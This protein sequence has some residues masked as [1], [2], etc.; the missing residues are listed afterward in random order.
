M[1]VM[2]SACPLVFVGS[3]ATNTTADRC[4]ESSRKAEGL[5]GRGLH[6]LAQERLPDCP[7][8]DSWQQ[9]GLSFQRR[10]AHQA[11]QPR[12]EDGELAYA[13]RP[14]SARHSLQMNHATPHDEHTAISPAQALL[15]C[16][17]CPNIQPKRPCFNLGHASTWARAF[18]MLRP[19]PGRAFVMLRTG[20]CHWPR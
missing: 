5:Q 14:A 19:G 20:P 1:P 15:R 18:V 12:H 6:D 8:Y 2:S 10:D 16:L 7:R 3:V 13:A 9:R 4:C 11:R 17:T